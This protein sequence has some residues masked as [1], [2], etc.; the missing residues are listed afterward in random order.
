M[1][2]LVTGATGFLGSQLVKKLAMQHEVFAVSRS[3]T[4]DAV[5]GVQVVKAD[6]G[7][8]FDP[9]V[10]PG[11]IDSVVHLAQ[12]ARYRDF[13]DGAD[14]VFSVNVSGTHRLFEYARKAKAKNFVMASTGSVYTPSPT[15]S[16]ED[17]PVA[18]S[19]FYSASKL[20]AE[21][22]L[23]PY[24]AFMKVSALRLF[25]LY[26]PGQKDKLIA[27]L[28]KRIQ[29]GQSLQISGSGDGIALNPTYIDDAVAVFTQAV[30]QSWE[31]VYNVAG[32]ETVTIRELGNSIAAALG[33]QVNFDMVGGDE[34][35][36]VLPDLTRLNERIDTSSF[37]SLGDGLEKML[38]GR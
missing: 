12:S 8:D 26:G 7:A 25:Y 37:V 21:D 38:S 22:L 6:L 11:E 15:P 36:S 29:S 1:R 14:D 24:G 20:A 13:P 3:G 34:P 9:S 35:V 19:D 10:L 32:P 27:I 16:R 4:M 5:S 18:P 2:I 28:A 31:G 17:V 30:E 23:R 33:T